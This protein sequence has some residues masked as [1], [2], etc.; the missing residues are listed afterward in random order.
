MDEAV[1]RVM[2]AAALALGAGAAMAQAL[3]DP[4]RPPAVLTPAAPGAAAAAS[5]AGPVLQSVLIGREAGGRQ[6]AVI[7]GETV[8]LGGKFRGAVLVRMTDTEVELKR[9]RERQGLKLS[10][11][12]G[13]TPIARS[14]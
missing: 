9:G 5:P 1:K 8:R 11:P 3:V 4:T 13:S 14:K 7:D 2:L 10:A 6:V 12:A